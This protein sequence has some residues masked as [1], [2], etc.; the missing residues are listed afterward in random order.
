M[1]GAG[2]GIVPE[3]LLAVLDGVRERDAEEEDC[4]GEADRED[5]D[6]DGRDRPVDVG[7]RRVQRRQIP[8]P[9]REQDPEKRQ[10]EGRKTR[11]DHGGSPSHARARQKAVEDDEEPHRREEAEEAE[12]GEGGSRLEQ[13]RGETPTVTGAEGP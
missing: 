7:E 1:R 5:E 3:Q 9:G 13:E 11:G 4:E 6:D 2:R 12:L 10:P 8:R